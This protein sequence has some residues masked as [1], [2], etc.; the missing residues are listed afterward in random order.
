MKNKLRYAFTTCLLI[1]FCFAMLFILT[2]NI[3][4]NWEMENKF[5]RIAANLML[6]YIIIVLFR[7][8]VLML[9]SFLEFMEKK[10]LPEVETYP[11]VTIIIPCF[12]EE[13]GIEK[14]INS[15][16]RINY[17]NIEI[18][19]VD[20]G[21]KDDTFII[22]SQLSKLDPRV[23]VIHQNNAG[24]A[25][26][27]NN[28]IS[29][30]NGDYFICMDAD[31]FLSPNVLLKSIPYF[32]QDYNLAAI[33]GT[34]LVGNGNNI[35]TKFQKLEYIIGL[36]FHKTAQSFL[37]VVTI[38]PGPIGVFS[39]EHVL[40]VGGYNKDTFAEDC[41]LSMR[42]LM[43]GYNIKYN[44]EI[45]ATTEAPEEVNQL[46]TQRYRWTRGM[47][48]SILKSLKVTIKRPSLRSILI[49]AYMFSETII[50]PITNFMFIL[51]TLQFALM[52]DIPQFLGP[53]FISLTFLEL[54]LCLYSI[55]VE[56]EIKMLF[57]LSIINKITY[58][59]ALEV[60]R[61]YS[62]LDEIFNLPMKWGALKRKGL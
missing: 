35:L 12:N 43:Q 23:R 37:N 26:A 41:D 33:A 22:A 25:Q 17:P 15:V 24:K 13:K 7:S 46:I 2:L 31:S 19:V 62:I 18:L 50:I 11:L 4:S 14:A 1:F 52:Y 61:F 51:L 49:N 55:I 6:Y 8:L 5:A 27:L 9:F 20:D 16:C 34:V 10:T 42:L 59:L 30:A 53:Y 38:V 39:K 45:T 54:T 29:Q 40:S 48:Q 56:K 44:S 3:E 60:I 58:G 28:G 36:N 32:E 57:T 21:S 47:I